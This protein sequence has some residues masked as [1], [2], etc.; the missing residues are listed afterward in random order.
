MLLQ[1]GEHDSA[2]DARTAMDLAL[3]K[4][5]HG[6]TFGTGTGGSSSSEKLAD[7]LAEHGHRSCL[8]DRKDMLSKFATGAFWVQVC[9]RN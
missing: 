3:L 5:K 1:A 8:L 9:G 6:P 2:I 4:I 7:V